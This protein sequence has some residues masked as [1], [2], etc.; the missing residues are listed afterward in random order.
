MNTALQRRLRKLEAENPGNVIA[1]QDLTNEELF[2]VLREVDPGLE[3]EA[4]IAWYETGEESPGFDRA[5]WRNHDPRLANMTD[6]Q[7][8]RLIQQAAHDATTGKRGRA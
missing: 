4:F 6:A 2:A 3:T 5:K 1:L 8:T 7:L